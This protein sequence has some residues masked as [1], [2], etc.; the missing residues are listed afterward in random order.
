VADAYLRLLTHLCAPA[1]VAEDGAEGGEGSRR[2]SGEAAAALYPH[3]MR[4]LYAAA[5]LATP[6][7]R[8]RVAW[9]LVHNLPLLPPGAAVP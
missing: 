8:R 6:A 7:L 1:A 2:L 5:S 4:L 9:L 3:L